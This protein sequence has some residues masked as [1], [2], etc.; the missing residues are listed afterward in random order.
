MVKQLYTQFCILIM[1]LQWAI[2][3]D[4]IFE[5]VALLDGAQNAIDGSALTCL[6]RKM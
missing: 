4:I 3:L 5:F 6:L 1:L 2:H